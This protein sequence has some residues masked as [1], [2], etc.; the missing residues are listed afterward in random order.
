MLRNGKMVKKRQFMYIINNYILILKT[1]LSKHEI[2]KM[3]FLN[4][5]E[6]IYF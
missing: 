3:L 4:I 2:R 6:I 1:V 5:M